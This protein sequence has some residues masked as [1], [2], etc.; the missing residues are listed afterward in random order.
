MVGH[1][2][3]VAN[4]AANGGAN[5]KQR[6][7]D[8]SAKKAHGG[9]EELREQGGRQ[10][11]ADEHDRRDDEHRTVGQRLL[12]CRISDRNE[13]ASRAGSRSGPGAEPLRL[14][15]SEHALL[16]GEVSECQYEENRSY[17]LNDRRHFVT[18]FASLTV[19]GGPGYFGLGGVVPV[20]EP[21]R[22]RD[23]PLE[24]SR[25]PPGSDSNAA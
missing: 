25:G 9:H 5:A 15:L 22:R 1:V 2:L 3:C 4:A 6:R 19:H 17:I 16:P 11:P 7:E 12:S 18:L 23:D 14:I 10:A 13:R 24:P 8:C 20:I 21:G